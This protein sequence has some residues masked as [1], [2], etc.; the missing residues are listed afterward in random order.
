MKPAVN[1][2]QPNPIWSLLSNSLING[3][4]IAEPDFVSAYIDEKGFSSCAG[5]IVIAEGLMVLNRQRPAF[6]PAFASNTS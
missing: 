4:K 2:V 6:R 1:P 3:T 5:S